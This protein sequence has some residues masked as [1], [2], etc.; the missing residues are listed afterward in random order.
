MSSEVLTAQEVADLLRIARKTVY[1]MVRANE[2]PCIKT[3]RV[4][5]FHRA[6]LEAWLS[7]RQT[8]CKERSLPGKAAGK[9]P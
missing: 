5:R 6:T 8:P 7:G 1:E 4:F 3:G 2:I 9:V